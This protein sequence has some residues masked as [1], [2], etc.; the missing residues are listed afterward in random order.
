[1]YAK[2]DRA[3]I[4]YVAACMKWRRKVVLEGQFGKNIKMQDA[5][6]ID[7]RNGKFLAGLIP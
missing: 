5:F 7:R 2:A 4:P 1:M 3:L 6:A